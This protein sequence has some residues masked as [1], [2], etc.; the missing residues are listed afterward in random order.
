MCGQRVIAC[1]N[2]YMTTCFGQLSDYVNL[3]SGLLTFSVL[4]YF[5]SSVEIDGSKG[6]SGVL[7]E[8]SSKKRYIFLLIVFLLVGAYALNFGNKIFLYW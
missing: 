1:L 7:K 2:L 5:F 6:N 3:F 4:S 8:A